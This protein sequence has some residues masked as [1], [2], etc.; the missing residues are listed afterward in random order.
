MTLARAGHD[1]EL[2]ARAPIQD[3]WVEQGDQ[4]LG[5]AIRVVTDP[6]D[7]RRASWILLATKTQDTAGAL[8]W[9]RA[10]ATPASVVVVLQNGIEHRE[11]LAE[12]GDTCPL[13]P[14][15]VQITVQPME[16]GQ[17]RHLR[18]ERIVVPQSPE[19]E[20]FAG[21]F[22]GSG[23]TIQLADDFLT[24]AWRKLLANAVANPITALTLRTAEVVAS[25]TIEGLVR[26][27]L[28]ETASVA[29][30]SGA[31][32]EETEEE[33]VYDSLRAFPGEVGTSMLFDRLAGRPLEQE[34]LTGAIVR[35]GRRVGVATPL[36]EMLLQLLRAIDE[37]QPATPGTPSSTG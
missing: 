19:G 5:G 12:I 13:L 35:T 27:L 25:E 16:R 11:R 20:R 9:I 29:R 15:L 4:R 7:L 37:A 30:A 33:R 1:V 28:H 24:A 32:L 14:A 2:C 21:L 31:L 10:A 8:G 23:I 22:T 18:G 36:N 34:A 26:A 6:K 3:I 17:V